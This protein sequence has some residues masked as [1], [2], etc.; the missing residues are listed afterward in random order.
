MTET[1][2]IHLLGPFELR[3][4]GESMTHSNWGSQ[5]T[6]TVGKILITN[7]DKVVTSDKLIDLL[8]PDEP[9]E[10][11][12]RRLHV[13]ISQLRNV[14]QDKKNLIQTVHGGYIFQPDDTC[15]LDV[16]AFQLHISQGQQFQETGQQI[17]AISAY[18]KGR[19]I[20]RGVFLAEDLYA[21]WTYNQREVLHES[22]I[23]L[24]IELSECYAQQGRYRLA[25][26]RARQ[27]LTQDHLR[28]TIYIRLMLYHYYAG[29][30]DQALRM[31]DRCQDVLETELGVPPLE[32]TLDLFKQIKTGKLWKNSNAFRYPPPIYEGRLFEVPYALSEIPLV[33]REREYAWLVSQWNDPSKRMILLEGQAGIGKSR[34]LNSFLDYLNSQGIRLLQ[35]QLSPS[36]HRPTAAIVTA[37][38]N[39]LTESALRKLSPAT[40][41]TLAVLL[42]DIHSR[43][44]SLPELPPLSPNG[45]HQRLKQALSALSTVCAPEPT[46][47]V[48]DDAQRL[49]PAAV[50]LITQLNKIFRVVLSFRSEDTPP[51][52]PIRK[53]FTPTGFILKPLTPQAIKGL[54]R[55]LSGQEHPNLA[56]QINNQSGGVPLFVVSLLQHMFETGQLFVNSG[57]DWEVSSQAPLSLPATLRET[58]EARL[59]HLNPI[60]RRIFD[61]A[62][63]IGG[64][65]DFSLL[66]ATTRQTEESLL[67]VIDALINAG[68]VIE[69]RSLGKPEFMISHD[70]YTEVAYETIPLVRRKG[71]HLQA[72]NTIETLYAGQLESYFPIL[73]DHF[74]QAEQPDK[75]ANYAALAGIQAINHFASDE[76]ILYLGMALSLTPK[77]NPEQLARLR[78]AREEVYDLLGLRKEQEEDL[79]ELESLY[80]SLPDEFQANIHLR[81]AAYEWI[82]GNDETANAALAEAID[83]ARAVGEKEIEAKALLLAGRAAQDYTL[84]E[85]HLQGALQIAQEM[86]FRALEGDT[87]R[88]LGNAAYWQNKYQQSRDLFTQALAIH[89]EVGDLRGELSA[90]N[91]LAM[92]NELIGDLPTSLKHYKKAVDICRKT[93]HRLAEGVITTN[94]GKLNTDLGHFSEARTL[95]EQALIIRKEIQNE[96]GVALALKHLGDLFRRTGQYDLALAQYTK[97][98]DINVKLQHKTQTFETIEA[99]SAL[100]RDLGDYQKAQS[101]SEQTAKNPLDAD[102]HQNIHFLTNTSLLNT[103]NGNPARALTMGEEALELAKGLPLLHAPALKN[104][105]HALLALGRA[106]EARECYQKAYESYLAYQQAHLALEPLAGM[107]K[108]SLL[109]DNS[110]EA[111]N[112]I[113]AILKAIDRGSLDGPDRSLWIYLI[114]YQVLAQVKE[115]RAHKTIRSAYRLLQQRADTISDDKKRQCYLTGVMENREIVNICNALVKDN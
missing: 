115:Q 41:A 11:A 102:S 60:Q 16:D 47:L 68:L 4:N 13:R 61:F 29:E 105:G 19:E 50:D 65:F 22:F 12:R 28:E 14:L 96:E 107:A 23:N 104:I 76:A 110:D 97:A 90:L 37:L 62:A 7:R 57:G 48:V 70:R 82:L 100:Y 85:E 79:I 75:A 99:F 33:S 89:Q 88:C 87:T 52:H 27:A 44:N 36:D 39:L 113:E 73:A 83:Q 24:L 91:N 95:L 69:P 5:Q 25:I 98:L 32:S 63:V 34:L 81:R 94:L 114:C 42:P 8:W 109:Q 111:F 10:S 51:E 15:W 58:I 53:T 31:F 84:A 64:K 30:R 77:E 112:S 20:Y 56:S 80:T 9:I 108:I 101:Y 40:L 45:E 66:Q 2:R 17:E 43:V 21:D 6:Q 67:A 92:V 55:Q 106:L 59:N 93:G 35:V 71:M 18:E 103:L 1:L 3:L 86:N 54:I 72:A 49:G 26:A 46:L 74:N 78:L 38:G